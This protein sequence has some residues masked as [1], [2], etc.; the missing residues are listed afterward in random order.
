MT[1]AYLD[2]ISEVE[3]ETSNFV[4]VLRKRA[5]KQPDK[6]GYVFLAGGEQEESHL[7]YSEL[8]RQARAIGTRLQMMGAAGQRVLLLYAPGLEYIAGFF[9]CLYAGAVAVPAYAPRLNQSL[10]RLQAI[11]LDAQASVAMTTKNLFSRIEPLLSQTPQLETLKWLLSDTLEDELAQQWEAPRISDSSLAFLQYTSGSTSTPKERR[12]SAR[13]SS[14][15]S[16]ARWSR[17]S[18]NGSRPRVPSKLSSRA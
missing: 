14:R 9:G 8:D 1:K 4:D 6:T 16:S 5:L 18:S 11:A 10:Q 3:F 13:K 7:T 15:T 2:S 17:R 12:K